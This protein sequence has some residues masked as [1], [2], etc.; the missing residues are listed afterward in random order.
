[1]KTKF[2]SRDLKS[3]L[4]NGPFTWPGGYPLY[5]ITSDGAALS[6]EAVR[7][8]FRAILSSVRSGS[9]DGWRVV[10]VDVNWEDPDLICDHTGE[11]IESAYAEA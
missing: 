5:F 2:S 3:A 4:R 6:F 7:A 9:N 1:M 10:A 11:H 8:N